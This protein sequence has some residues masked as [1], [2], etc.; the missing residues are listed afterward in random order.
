ME[1][2]WA[3]TELTVE[4][5]KNNAEWGGQKKKEVETN[6]NAGLWRTLK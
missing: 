4:G 5:R 2:H 3:E 6:L 1:Q